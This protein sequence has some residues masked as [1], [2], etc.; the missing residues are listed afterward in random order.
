MK[1]LEELNITE[2]AKLEDLIQKDPVI[3]NS[4]D[5][6]HIKAR[7]AYLTADEQ[8]TFAICFEK[9]ADPKTPVKK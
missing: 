6:K 2:R 7:K 3:L 1:N 9:T 8:K 4:A 5:K